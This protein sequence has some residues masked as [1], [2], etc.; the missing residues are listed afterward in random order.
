M[1]EVEFRSQAMFNLVSHFQT[2]YYPLMRVSIL[3]SDNPLI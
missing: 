3:V 1:I 2:I